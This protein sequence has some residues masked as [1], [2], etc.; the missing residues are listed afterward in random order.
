MSKTIKHF[1]T[2][3]LLIVVLIPLIP[4]HVVAATTVGDLIGDT[5]VD[6]TQNPVKLLNLATLKNIDIS[7]IKYKDKTILDV[8]AQEE[9]NDYAFADTT[10][11][12]YSEAL[13]KAR[14]GLQNGWT[15]NSVITH[16]DAAYDIYDDKIAALATENLTADDVKTA[17]RDY[18]K[19][20][21]ESNIDVG[22]LEEQ[23]PLIVSCYSLRSISIIENSN[24]MEVS[25]NFGV[26]ETNNTSLECVKSSW[27]TNGEP[28]KALLNGTVTEITDTS[29]STSIGG[30]QH[31]LTITYK[32][33]TPIKLLDEN[34][35]ID[36]YVPQG[37][38]ILS[39]EDNI[40]EITIKY[41]DK[42]IDLLS[43]LNATGKILIN[44]YKR[45]QAEPYD[46]NRDLYIENYLNAHIR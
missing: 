26:L 45:T 11:L 28:L 19:N 42:N 18:I 46:A 8:L 37:S 1:V 12:V 4:I 29:L 7:E 6:D 2:A 41:N 36:A 10:I 25:T 39:S 15:A 9:K 20:Y 27:Y 31:K 44:E 40:F 3:L 32:S 16:A 14:T 38:D 17:I 35:I 13:G 21:V 24:K 5:Q 43:L 30:E 34:I 22:S 33:E 23:L